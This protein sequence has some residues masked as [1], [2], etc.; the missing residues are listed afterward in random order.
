MR[1]A[2]TAL[3][4]LTLYA[5]PAQSVTP[6]T[7]FRLLSYQ[8]IVVNGFALQ[9]GT[10]YIVSYEVLNEDGSSVY[11]G[12]LYP[13]KVKGNGLYEAKII[14]DDFLYSLEPCEEY[15]V[16]SW[17]HDPDGTWADRALDVDGHVLEARSE[18]YS[19]C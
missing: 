4:A 2:L 5:A 3:I 15:E 6:D 13:I 16:H 9:A 11:N 17:L 14:P 8:A 12:S 19:D 1:V 7:S 18:I 10:S